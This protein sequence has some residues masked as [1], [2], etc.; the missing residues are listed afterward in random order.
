MRCLIDTC[1]FINI[2][3]DEYVSE[4][5]KNLLYDYDNVIYISSESIKELVHLFQNDKITLKKEYR[6]DFD[7]FSFIESSNIIVKYVTWEHLKK[8]SSLPIIENHNDPSDRLIIAQA[9][10]EGLTLISSDLKFK[11]YRK[12]NLDLIMNA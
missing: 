10:C 6:K 2:I 11:K 4:D 7:L 12:Y 8:L 3:T 9:I 5:I 1:L